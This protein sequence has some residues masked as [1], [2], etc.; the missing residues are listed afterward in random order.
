MERD[1]SNIEAGIYPQSVL[2]PESPIEHWARFPR[3]LADSIRISRRRAQGRTTEFSEDGSRDL[4]EELPRYYRRCFHFQTGG[5]LSPESAELYEHQVEI[6]FAGMADSMRRMVI[7]PLKKRFGRDH[8]G[9]GLR[10]L[11][12]GAGTGRATRFMSLAFPKAQIVATDLSPA[13]LRTG[14]KRLLRQ[15][16]VDFLQADATRLPFSEAQFDAV[17]SVF[18]F[19][20]MP[21]AERER[22]IAESRRVCKARGV[23][24]LVDSLQLGDVPAMDFHLESFPRQ[25]HEPFFRNY[26]AHPMESLLKSAGLKQV[27]V[28]T[29]FFSKQVSGAVPAGRA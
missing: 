6:L 18:L 4:L 14:Q 10:F 27:R 7:E 24:A 12:L 21:L 9:K 3:V 5:Y 1:L 13:Y 2:K 26:A 8:D 29:G 23:V 22:V 25:F 19:H 16:R 17:Y 20:E 11:E 15:A 28:E